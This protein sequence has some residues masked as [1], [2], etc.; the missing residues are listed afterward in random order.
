MHTHQAL[1]VSMVVAPTSPFFVPFP[2]ANKIQ[3]RN[4]NAVI[5]QKNMRMYFAQK[6]HRPRYLGLKKLQRLKEQTSILWEIG[7][8]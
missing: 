1:M 4:A 7:E 3:Y 6:K 5:L 8:W 2:V